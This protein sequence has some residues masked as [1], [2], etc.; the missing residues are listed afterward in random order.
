MDPLP[1]SPRW[2]E[3]LAARPCWAAPGTF[4]D[5]S[6][7][8]RTV[9]CTAPGSGDPVART[10]GVPV[11]S[12]VSGDD[13]VGVHRLMHLVLLLLLLLRRVGIDGHRS[14][15]LSVRGWLT[16][17]FEARERGTSEDEMVSRREGLEE[18]R[19]SILGLRFI[20]ADRSRAGHV[21]EPLGSLGKDR[22]C[23]TPRSARYLSSADNLLHSAY[24]SQLS[25]SWVHR[26]HSSS[27]LPTQRWPTICSTN[28]SCSSGAPTS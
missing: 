21:A 27:L 23:F 1:R 20:A 2:E 19:N 4:V 15:V 25:S 18:T 17:H 12:S 11:V 28:H 8:A 24:D 9:G 7:A 14:V 16:V 22:Q 6:P 26:T 5:S 13:I 10:P 3:G